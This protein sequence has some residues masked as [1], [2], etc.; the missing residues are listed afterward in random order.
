MQAEAAAAAASLICSSA[1][2]LVLNAEMCTIQNYRWL[3]SKLQFHA[4]GIR[5]PSL[6][7][8]AAGSI[9]YTEEGDYYNT[10]KLSKVLDKVN[11]NCSQLNSK[12]SFTYMCISVV[13]YVAI[14]V[15]DG[16]LQQV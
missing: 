14:V 15:R 7:H 5:E 12:R 13:M 8:I 11:A 10:R 9:L 6:T 2:D 4:N 3:R 16:I 1:P